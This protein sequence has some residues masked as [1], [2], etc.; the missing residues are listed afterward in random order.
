MYKAAVRWKQ[1]LGTRLGTDRIQATGVVNQL[2]YVEGRV[3]PSRLPGLRSQEIGQGWESSDCRWRVGLSP[4]GSKE[5]QPQPVC[6]PGTSS[7]AA[8]L[9][10]HAGGLPTP[11]RRGLHQEYLF[12]IINY[13]DLIGL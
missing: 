7:S 13:Q 1:E 3:P 12:I 2:L 5:T 4:L 10:C 11:H 6:G 8:A 9:T